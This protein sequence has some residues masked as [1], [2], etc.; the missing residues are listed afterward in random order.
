MSEGDEVFDRD[1][2]DTKHQSDTES[3]DSSGVRSA[4]LPPRDDHE[5]QWR[6][7]RTIDASVYT[8]ESR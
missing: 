5:S 1:H 2:S 7:A 3:S 4:A 6:M 8:I